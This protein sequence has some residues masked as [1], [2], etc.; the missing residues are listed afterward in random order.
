MFPRRSASHGD[1]VAVAQRRLA[2]L[3]EQLASVPG[4]A[5]ADVEETS[6][7]TD[8]V[9]DAEKS[10]YPPPHRARPGRHA[11]PVSRAGWGRW[12]LGPHQVAVAAVLVAVVVVIVGWWSLRSSPESAGAPVVHRSVPPTTTAESD[13]TAA[14]PVDGLV[15]A[16]ARTS[17][18]PQHTRAPATLQARSTPAPRLVV[19]VAGKVRQPGIVALPEGSR[20]VDALRAAGGARKGVNLTALNL[21]RPLVDGEQIVVGIDIPT[22]PAAPVATGAARAGPQDRDAVVNLNTATASQL[23]T[24]PGV[25]PVTAQKI[26]AWRVANGAFRE[27]DDLLEISGIGDKTL[28]EIAPHARV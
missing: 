21:A 3:A 16:A 28:A 20:V 6:N 5:D 12:T 19:D 15:A 4:S 10:P 17:A 24:L 1:T 14:A 23:E 26:V 22:V 2:A 13:A 9:E 7:A 18:I 27:V 11:A 25:G 8:D